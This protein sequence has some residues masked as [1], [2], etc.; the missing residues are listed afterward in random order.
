MSNRI[1]ILQSNYIPWKGYFDII[2]SVDEFIF[3][4]E[5]QYTKNDWRNRN[6]IKTPTGVQWITIPVFQ[7][8]LNQKISETKVSNHKWNT[9]NWNKLKAN[10]SQAPFFKTH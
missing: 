5:A 7:K 4:D 8:N 6:K 1:A 3:Y 10:Y 2:G 9:K